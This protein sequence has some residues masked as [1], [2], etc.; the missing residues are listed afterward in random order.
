MWLTLRNGYYMKKV[1]KFP[2]PEVHAKVRGRAPASKTWDCT[3]VTNWFPCCAADGGGLCASSAGWGEA[4]ELPPAGPVFYGGVGGLCDASPTARGL[5]ASLPLLLWVKADSV[6]PP[7]AAAGASR[8]RASLP[9][10]PWVQ[11]SSV[12]LSCYCRGYKQA[13]CLPPASTG[14]QRRARASDPAILLLI[15]YFI[16]FRSSLRMKV[17]LVFQCGL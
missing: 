14:D 3:N 6:L 7:A 5:C 10:P 2:K 8:L 1:L 15:H 13:L 11:A 9:L 4:G 16:A 12:P 17:W